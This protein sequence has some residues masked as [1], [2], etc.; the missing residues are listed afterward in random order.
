MDRNKKH[1]TKQPAVVCS[2]DSEFLPPND[3]F[4]ISKDRRNVSFNS[5][6]VRIY[7]L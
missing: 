7:C 1:L 6:A 5:K 3:H 2:A 4:E